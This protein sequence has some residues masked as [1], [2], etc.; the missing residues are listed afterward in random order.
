RMVFLLAVPEARAGHA[1]LR[2]LARLARLLLDEGFRT[3]LEAART[4]AVPTRSRRS[5][6]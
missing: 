6:S 4:P 3:G 2:I 1:H 5:R